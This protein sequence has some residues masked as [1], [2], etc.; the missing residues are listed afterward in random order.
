MLATK[1]MPDELKMVEPSFSSS[2]TDLIIDLDY[3]RRKELQGST[4]LRVFFELKHIFHLLESIGSVRIE[5]DN[6]TIADITQIAL[7]L[8]IKNFYTFFKR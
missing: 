2:L 4:H 5:G 1:F 7:L 6:M 3:L 8:G